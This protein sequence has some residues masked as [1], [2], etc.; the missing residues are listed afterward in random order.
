[1]SSSTSQTPTM[2]GYLPRLPETPQLR[3]KCFCSALG[4]AARNPYRCDVLSPFCNTL[5]RGGSARSSLTRMHS[6]I[7]VAMLQCC[8]VGVNCT[9]RS[10]QADLHQP[11]PNSICPSK[12]D[13]RRVETRTV[14]SLHHCCPS[15]GQDPDL[16][17]AWSA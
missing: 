13:H 10:G 9:L 1:M 7:S 15:F 4:A 5:K 11:M 14:Q 12:Q 2:F 8:T 6:P 17:R 3:I 16:C